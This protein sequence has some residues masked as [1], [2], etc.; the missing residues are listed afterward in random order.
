MFEMTPTAM[1][2]RTMRFRDE[3]AQ[4]ERFHAL[5]RGD[6]VVGKT[7]VAF[8]AMRLL[9]ISLISRLVHIRLRPA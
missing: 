2:V 5:V 1:T 9:R 8:P 6:K 7:P 3:V 4:A